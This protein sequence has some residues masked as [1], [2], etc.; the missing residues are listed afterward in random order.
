MNKLENM[1]GLSE[2]HRYA[3]RPLEVVGGLFLAKQVDIEQV[4]PKIDMQRNGI[5]QQKA[6][7]G[8]E[9]NGKTVVAGKAGRAE[10]GADI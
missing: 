1:S 7:A 6:V 9:I 2:E 5:G 4:V 10:A 3:E 8:A